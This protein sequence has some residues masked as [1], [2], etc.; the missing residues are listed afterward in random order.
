[1][2]H[3][4]DIKIDDFFSKQLIRGGWIYDLLDKKINIDNDI[5]NVLEIGCASGGNLYP[6]YKKG[7]NISGFDYDQKF[8]SFARDKGMNVLCGDY[9]NKIEENSQ[10]I[11]LLVHV[12]EHFTD[13][14]KEMVKIISK[15]KYSGYLYIEVP[16]VM[17]M[18]DSLFS[19][20]K[21][22]QND[23]IFHFNETYLKSFFVVLGLK[24]IH[25]DEK[26]RF[27]LRKPNELCMPT[28]Y[29]FNFDL[30]KV[31]D[32]IKLVLKKKYFLNDLMKLIYVRMMIVKLLEKFRLKKLIKRVVNGVD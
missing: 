25:S 9:Y 16:G 12:L 4:G 21:Y 20:L 28:D 29:S 27:I 1:M 8:T 24:I 31:V 14:V 26:C 30:K 11:V 5:L 6:Y 32:S 15:V 3:R 17:D 19:P 23:H 13:P 10:D 2:L 18:S 22:F 7:K